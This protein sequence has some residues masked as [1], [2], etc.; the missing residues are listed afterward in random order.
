MVGEAISTSQTQI[1]THIPRGLLESLDDIR[2]TR[3]DLVL[4]AQLQA[5]SDDTRPNV[6][7]EAPS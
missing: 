2:R 7:A 5:E 4:L 3:V 1:R 6:L